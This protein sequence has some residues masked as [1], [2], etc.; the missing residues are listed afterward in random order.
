MP[1]PR[2]YTTYTKAEI[3]KSTAIMANQKTLEGVAYL[4][5]IKFD[6]NDDKDSYTSCLHCGCRAAQL[7]Q[8][9]KKWHKQTPKEYLEQFPDAVLVCKNASNRVSGS[10]NPGYQHGGKLS[11]FSDNFIKYDGLTEQQIQKEKQDVINKA[12]QTRK[13]NPD[14]QPTRIEYY[15]AQGMTEAEATIA[16]AKRQT[17]FSKEI[18]V[19]KYGDK[20]GEEIWSA[21]QVKWH[22]SYKK[23]N[24][25]KISQE[26]FWGIVDTDNKYIHARFA[27]N[28]YGQ[29]KK[30]D[31]TTNYEVVIVD[32]IKPDF[33]YGNKI[34]EFNGTYWHGQ[35]SN[36][37]REAKR[38][39]KLIEDGYEVYIVDEAEYNKN[40]QKVI[41]GCIN[42]LSK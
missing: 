26:L 32:G 19:E 27:E 39:Q 42:F 9:L 37:L 11:K 41:I 18:C 13:E 31:D 15:L 21:R 4:S 24:Y 30:Y 20:L 22:T 7:D 35:R 17:T 23:S 34:I 40:K 5:K 10:N 38:T 6:D 33:L 29:K 2:H 14:K 25:S 28:Q 8:H 16:L 3:L 36:P 1:A 12:N